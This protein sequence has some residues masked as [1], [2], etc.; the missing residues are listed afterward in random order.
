MMLSSKAGKLTLIFVCAGIAL[1]G[2]DLFSGIS[3]KLSMGKSSYT[4]TA[5]A[6]TISGEA[7][8]SKEAKAHFKKAHEF[9]KSRQLDEALKEFQETVKLSPKTPVAHYWL[10]MAFFYKRDSKK[11][12]EQFNKALELEPKNYHAM[13]MLG[14]IYTLDKNRLDDAVKYLRMALAINPEFADARAD[15]AHV[16]VMRG[17]L[18]QAIAEFGIIFKGEPRYAMYHYELGRL[19]ES[20]KALDRAKNE[21]KRALV[22][23]PRMSRAKE[24]LKRIK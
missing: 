3:M 17:K 11:A 12:I 16:Y 5:F 18:S 9:L 6:K 23:D 20:M 13:A 15:M 14:K 10:G 8:L 22:P 2:T 21:F 4:G 7:P 19:F 24:A 1:A